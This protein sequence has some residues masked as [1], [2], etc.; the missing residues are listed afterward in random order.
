MPHPADQDDLQA[1]DQA[2]YFIASIFLGRGEFDKSEQSNLSVARQ[3]AQH[4]EAHYH[5][6]RGGMVYAVLPSGRSVLVPPEYQPKEKA[7]SE[8][9]TNADKEIP[10]FLKRDKIPA[11][12]LAKTN[13][14]GTKRAPAAKIGKKKDAVAKETKAV[15][16]KAVKALKPVKAPKAKAEKRAKAPRP[17]GGKRGAILEAAKRGEMPSP[18][19][20][21]AN[22][23]RP[24]RGR[25]E[26][27]VKMAKAGDVKGLKA[28]KINPT[29]TSPKAIARYR[30][31]AVTALEAKAA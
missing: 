26:E 24:H 31:L 29:S 10:G 7:M 27:V 23:H 18:P 28:F 21:S 5:N 2:S 13:G 9:T 22:T 20:F 12:P 8:V 3:I 14:A 30:D 11:S 17:A 1:I 4:M 25:L 15:K 6:G 16:A 19:D